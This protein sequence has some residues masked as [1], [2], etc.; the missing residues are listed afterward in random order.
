M[1]GGDYLLPNPDLRADGVHDP[2]FMY[3][4][5]EQITVTDGQPLGAVYDPYFDRT[6]AHFSGH[7]NAPS[8]PDPNGYA[9]GVAKGGYTYAAHPLFSCYFM[10]GA[11]AMLEIAEKLIAQALGQD[12]M[13]DTDLPRAGRATLR[14]APG[15]NSDV[16]HLLHAN[17]ALRGTLGGGAIQPIQDL[18]SIG[19]ITVSLAASGPVAKVQLVPAGTRLAHVASPD[20]ISFTVPVV[21]GHQMVEVVY[22]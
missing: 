22:R 9:A 2:L 5:S 4:P 19:P 16:L 11:V 1:A 10:S 12:K 13:I 3:L 7:V 6:P 17:P 15:R 21:R 8:R 18:I 14:H 20:R